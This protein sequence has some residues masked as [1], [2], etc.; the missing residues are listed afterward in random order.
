MKVG[1]GVL[2]FDETKMEI[3]FGLDTKCYNRWKAKPACHPETT[4]STEK[5]GGGSVVLIG[6]FFFFF[7]KSAE[8]FVQTQEPEPVKIPHCE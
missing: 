4:V 2:W 8:N 3:F 6:C 1:R 7:F 5:H